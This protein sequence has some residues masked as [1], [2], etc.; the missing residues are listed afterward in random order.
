MHLEFG[1]DSGRIGYC[2]LAVFAQVAGGGDRMT[3]EPG[4]RTLEVM[5]WCTGITRVNTLA[6]QIMKGGEKLRPIDGS[7][8]YCYR[9][10]RL[11]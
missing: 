10:G 1:T 2:G 5:G 3:L 9:G 8:R 7:D 6:A 4:R 11:P